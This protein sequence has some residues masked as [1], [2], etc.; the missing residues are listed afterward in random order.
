MSTSHIKFLKWSSWASLV[1]PLI[2]YVLCKQAFTHHWFSHGTWRDVVLVRRYA[3]LVS[4]IIGSLVLLRD[5]GSKQWR[6]FWLPLASLILTYLLYIET[7]EF[8]LYFSAPG[9]RPWLS[10]AFG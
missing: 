5:A 9:S 6:L 1:V 10:Y 4:S 3:F 8:T 2:A 7:A